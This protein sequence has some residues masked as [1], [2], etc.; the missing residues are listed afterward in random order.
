MKY[1][2]IRLLTLVVINTT[3]FG[4]ASVPVESDGK[5]EVA[6]TFKAPPQA[7]ASVYVYRKNSFIGADLKKTYGLIKSA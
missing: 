6:K 5:N 2:K 7:I 4:C 1:L 3:L